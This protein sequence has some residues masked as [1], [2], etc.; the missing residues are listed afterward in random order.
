[1]NILVLA[2]HPDDEVLGCGG[3]IARLSAEGHKVTIAILGQGAASRFPKG[4]NEAN[5]EISEL[6]ER[7]KEAARILGAAEVLHYDLPDNR[8]DSGNLLDIVKLIESVGRHTSPDKVFTQHGGDLNVDHHITFR[9]TLTAFRPQ[10][11]S[12]VK[13][14]Y[15]Y[16]VAS[17]TEWA[18]ASLGSHFVPNTFVDVSDYVEKKINALNAYANEMREFP[19]PRSLEAIQNQMLERGARIG[20]NVAEAFTCVW[21][22]M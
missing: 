21:R 3:T 18:F 2:A 7:S 19:H 13:A 11:G 15:A 22:R 14:L 20:V 8:F 4:S 16:E 17:S 6:R 5:D 9:A 10:P 1:M 12:R